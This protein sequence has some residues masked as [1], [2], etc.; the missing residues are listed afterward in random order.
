MHAVNFAS[1]P[2]A[3]TRLALRGQPAFASSTVAEPDERSAV[4]LKYG[5]DT[6]IKDCQGLWLGPRVRVVVEAALRACGGA[7]AILERALMGEAERRTYTPAGHYVLAAVLGRSQGD[8][9]SAMAL[10]LPSQRHMLRQ[11]HVGQQVEEALF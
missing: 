5:S 6:H 7:A 1:S 9:H 2:L 3:Q 11:S 4:L 10:A 8:V